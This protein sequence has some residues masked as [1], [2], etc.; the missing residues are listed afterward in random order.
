MQVVRYVANPG[1]RYSDRDAEVI[2]SFLEEQFGEEPCT[3]AYVVQAARSS[4]SPI[5]RF[6]EWDDGVAAER[7]RETQARQ[8]LRSIEVVPAD[9]GSPTRAFHNITVTAGE[10]TSYVPAVVVWERP[11][12][13]EQV[14]A[15]A[16][17][18]LRVWQQ[19]YKDYKGLASLAAQV[20]QLLEAE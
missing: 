15:K 12:L 20:E 14:V 4:R 17:H 5:H 1:S 6:F 2:G 10:P 7:Y 11:D 16:L 9:G 19:R 3:P 18:E 8:M 13:S